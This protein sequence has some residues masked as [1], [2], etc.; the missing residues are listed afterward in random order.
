CGIEFATEHVLPLLVP[1]LLSQ[2]LNVQQFAKYMAFVKDILRKV[3]EKKGVTLSNTGVSEVIK[4]SPGSVI[5]PQQQLGQAN[6]PGVTAPSTTR[7]SPSWDED[8]TSSRGPPSVS[9]QSTSSASHPSVPNHH[10]TNKNDSAASTTQPLPSCPAVDLEWPPRS[11]PLEDSKG[12]KGASN[13][14]SFDD[15]DPFANWPPPRAPSGSTVSSVPLNNGTP[16]SSFNT[17][18][19]NDDAMGNKWS[20][21]TPMSYE[22]LKQNQGNSSL[23]FGSGSLGYMKKTHESSTSE[24]PSMDIGSIFSSPNKS[25][26]AIASLRIAPP[27]S[28]AIGR[29]RG[30]GRGSQGQPGTASSSSRKSQPEQ[31]N[32]LDLL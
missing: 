28:T 27:P 29:G 5:G 1:L 2:H 10:S 30:R 19:P 21:G 11:S 23:N 17:N 25:E 6:K 24:K 32:L 15:I 16:T 31:P 8:W 22:P 12:R 9:Q 18:G 26:Q 4:P 20:F 14:S 13:G 3:E 7:S